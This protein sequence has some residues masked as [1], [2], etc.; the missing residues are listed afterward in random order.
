M[1]QTRMIRLVYIEKNTATYLSTHYSLK[2]NKN[3]KARSKKKKMV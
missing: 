1:S 3:K 2:K